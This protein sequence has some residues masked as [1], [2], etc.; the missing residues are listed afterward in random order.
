MTFKNDC[1]E[2]D[3]IV[4][5]DRPQCDIETKIEERDVFVC[6][7]L[8]NTTEFIKTELSHESCVMG[9]NPEKDQFIYEVG[10]ISI[11]SVTTPT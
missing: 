6:K 11:R 7:Y 1:V 10:N 3:G 4:E 2:V 5:D 8:K 9:E